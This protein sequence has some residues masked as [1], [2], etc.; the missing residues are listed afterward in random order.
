MRCD[1]LFNVS[2]INVQKTKKN[3][4]MTCYKFTGS[5]SR[6]PQRWWQRLYLFSRL[7]LLQEGLVRCCDDNGRDTCQ[8][9]CRTSCVRY[10]IGENGD[11]GYTSYCG[12]SPDYCCYYRGRPK[13]CKDYRRCPQKQPQCEIKDNNSTFSSPSQ[14]KLIT[15]HWPQTG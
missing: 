10:N 5:F 12:G 14:Q 4:S 15:S 9:G 1:C 8:K 11:R 6:A 3:N 13:C 2:G 7:R